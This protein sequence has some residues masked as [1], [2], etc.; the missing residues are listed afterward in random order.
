MFGLG[1]LKRKV[2][3]HI[4][5]IVEAKSF[6]FVLYRILNL[7]SCRLHFFPRVFFEGDIL[8]W[9]PEQHLNEFM[10]CPSNS[11]FVDVGAYVGVWTLYM[12]RRGIKVV[13][14]EPSPSSF[15]LLTRLTKR[16]P[17]VT[18]LPYALG[19]G[20]YFAN[21]NLHVVHGNDS[22]VNTAPDFSGKRVKTVVRA[23][24]SFN[25]QKVGLIK[26]DTEGYE[27]PVL[28]GAK[29]TIRK[30]KPRLIIEVHAPYE[31]QV[32]KILNILKDYGYEWVMRSRPPTVQPHVIGSPTK[33]ARHTN[34][35]HILQ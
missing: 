30:W 33:R 8:W 1:K 27:V 25:I 4:H 13:A 19:E 22:L 2:N 21:L 26:I 14:F 28:L 23:L 17:H 24:D 6:S 10:V 29:E 9:S 34:S 32:A 5:D 11:S 12:A 16:Y 7:I 15:R 18:V 20:N 35:T 31:E 3:K